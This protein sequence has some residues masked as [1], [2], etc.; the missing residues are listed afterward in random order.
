MTDVDLSDI[1]LAIARQISESLDMVRIDVQPRSL[2]SLLQGAAKF[3]Q[4]EIELSTEA[5]VPGIGSIKASTEDLSLSSGIGK[6][7]A[8]A[9]NN[10]ELRNRLRQYLEPR[11]SSILDA[12]NQELVQPCI[13]KLAQ[14][15]KAGLVVIVDNLDRLENTLK[16]IGRPQA[17]YLFV[18]QAEHLKKLKCHVIYTMPLGLTFS[19]EFGRLRNCFG[20]D[21]EVLALVPI[22]LRDGSACQEGME[23]MRQIVLTRAFPD[24]EPDERL[25][26]ISEV[27]DSPETLEELCRISGGHVRNLLGIL[28][29]CLKLEDPPLSRSCLEKVIRQ[30][31]DTLVQ[32]ITD[33]EWELLSQVNKQHTVVG[34]L[35]YQTLVR[36]LLV[37][38]YEYHGDR[39]FS[40]N[41]ILEEAEKLKQKSKSKAGRILDQFN[42]L[43]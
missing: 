15:G 30:L 3:L 35:E 12:I 18:D 21:P 16:P 40:V 23:L 8:K 4:T 43:S 32:S 20:V 2:K 10:S 22:Q 39:W 17:E 13:E 5:S 34:E 6:I 7:T 31:R 9:K 11:T 24:V 14:I 27:F 36:N 26:L 25:N 41:P 28:Y 42:P 37:F 33:E 38:G 29:R 1:L 19:K